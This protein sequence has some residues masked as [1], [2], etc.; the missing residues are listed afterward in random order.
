MALPADSARAEAVVWGVAFAVSTVFAVGQIV[1]VLAVAPAMIAYHGANGGA[2]WAVE[3]AAALGPV[4]IGVSLGV[5]D[6]AIFALFVWL[7][8]RYWIGLAYVPPLI[9][10]GLGSIVIWSLV[11]GAIAGIAAGTA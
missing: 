1:T 6:L 5:V 8:R 9:F 7:A 4:L 10:I 3:T 2:M 11:S